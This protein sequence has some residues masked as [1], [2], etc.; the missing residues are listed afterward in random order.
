[1][2][3]FCPVLFLLAV[4]L[5]AWIPQPAAM[6]LKREEQ[7]L[8][9]LS[10]RLV[11]ARDAHATASKAFAYATIS[12]LEAQKKAG[13]SKE[14]ATP[15]MLKAGKKLVETSELVR[16]LALE[17]D[18]RQ[19]Y[20][21]RQKEADAPDA[22]AAD[23]Y[24]AAINALSPIRYLGPEEARERLAEA[25]ARFQEALE[26]APQPPSLNSAIVR[27]WATVKWRLA[28]KF[29]Q[30]ERAAVHAACAPLYARALEL[31][32]TAD[33]TRTV[34]FHW[35]AFLQQQ[36]VERSGAE[37]AQFFREADAK[38]AQA[39]EGNSEDRDVWGKRV[40]ERARLAKGEESAGLYRK[41]LA[42][43]AE[44]A[45]SASV[46]NTITVIQQRRSMLLI[47]YAKFLQG[48]GRRQEALS[49]L[50]EAEKLLRRMADD[51]ENVSCQMAKVSILQGRTAECEE[52]LN[53]CARGDGMLHFPLKEL[54]TE[55][56]WAAVRGTPWFLL[57]LV[58]LQMLAGEMADAYGR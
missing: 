13:A 57:D 18:A 39:M 54:E 25:D 29:P 47:E 30:K 19:H 2:R 49:P 27:D 4:S 34:F 23:K 37:R 53:A 43:Y 9:A 48:E 10:S 11:A 15:A 35:G 3:W 51:G 12:M 7:T 6:N 26:Q 44:A 33:D 52:W 50:G 28:M 56:E 45:N 21:T 41:A 5:F 46:K 24:H 8:Q 20:I 40:A 36:G 38:Y 1:M 22:T 32:A 42:L 31:A 17:I 14:I 16:V 55:P 58:K